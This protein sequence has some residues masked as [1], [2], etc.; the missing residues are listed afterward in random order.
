M[1][2]ML[3]QNNNNEL[4]E[5]N[6]NQV[7]GFLISENKDLKIPQVRIVN[8]LL[9]QD[10]PLLKTQLSDATVVPMIRA[11]GV[12]DCLNLPEYQKVINTYCLCMMSYNRLR[13]RELI[14]SVNPNYK[15]KKTGFFS[16]LFGGGD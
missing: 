3:L 14:E 9:R 6:N 8:E 2:V 13:V 10:K 1:W 12:T 7:G 15:P 11:Q 16:K 4:V 5:T